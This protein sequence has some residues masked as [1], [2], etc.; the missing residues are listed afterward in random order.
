M[1]QERQVFIYRFDTGQGERD[2]VSIL[3]PDWAFEHGQHPEAI[4]GVVGE[5]ADLDH[6]GP[7]DVQEN[8]TFLRLLSRVLY[9]HLDQDEQLRREAEIQANDLYRIDLVTVLPG[10]AVQASAK[11]RV[12]RDQ[13]MLVRGA[14]PRT[15][16]GPSPVLGRG[17]RREGPHRRVV[18]I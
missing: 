2:V 5:G 10:R 14:A 7:D 16:L 3:E 11:R 6:L 15:A 1:T 13:V 18:R 17:I 9:E 8:P 4:M 12:W